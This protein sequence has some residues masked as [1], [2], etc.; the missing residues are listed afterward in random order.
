MADDDED[1]RFFFARALH[2]IAIPTQLK[3]VEDG[4]VLM[5]YLSA[6]PKNI[7]DILFLDI[8]MP[9]KNGL[10]CLI[11]VKASKSIADFPVIIYSTALT[12]SVADV[13]YQKGAHYYM[14]KPDLSELTKQLQWIL[15]RLVS[16]NL[17]RVTR[18]KFVLGMQEA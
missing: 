4:E 16:G 13:F 15:T 9:R 1:D 7:P 2:G 8:N 10:E 18:D 12:E 17:E 5:N 14:R 3:P 11:E 6:S